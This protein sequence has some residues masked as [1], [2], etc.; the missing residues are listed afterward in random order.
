MQVTLPRHSCNVIPVTNKE[1]YHALPTHPQM[2]FSFQDQTTLKHKSV[3]RDASQNCIPSWGSPPPWGNKIHKLL[4]TK[5][6]TN[7]AETLTGCV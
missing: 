1:E 5:S 2:K 4:R 3:S 7:K 6:A